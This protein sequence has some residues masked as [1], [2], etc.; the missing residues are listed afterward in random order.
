MPEHY[1][2]ILDS[3][4]LGHLAT[5]GAD[6]KPRV[7][8][9]RFLSDGEDVYLGIEPG[10]AR[11]RNPARASLR[12]H[13]GRRSGA[14]HA[15]RRNPGRGRR[16]RALRNARLGQPARARVHRGRLH[17]GNGGRPAR[18]GGDPG[19]CLDGAG[20]TTTRRGEAVLK[21]RRHWTHRPRSPTWPRRSR[22]PQSPS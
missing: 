14:P 19:R 6:G 2:D 3:R 8:P 11:R 15:L 9:V 7:N 22:R 17:Q 20:L 12:R 18:Q 21:R 4:A 13:V 10:I 1:R 16:V 5:I